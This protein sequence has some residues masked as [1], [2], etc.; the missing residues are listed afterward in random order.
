MV[1]KKAITIS[2]NYMDIIIHFLSYEKHSRK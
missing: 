2:F 1:T